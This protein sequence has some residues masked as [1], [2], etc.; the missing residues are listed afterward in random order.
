MEIF[1]SAGKII[2]IFFV[3]DSDNYEYYALIEYSD[4]QSA[5]KAVEIF[6]KT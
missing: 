6:N 4:E 2:N 1:K 3:K 5:L